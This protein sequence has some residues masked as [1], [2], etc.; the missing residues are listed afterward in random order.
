V[1]RTALESFE[2]LSARQWVGRTRR[3]LTNPIPGRYL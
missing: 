2:R 1:L 3:Q